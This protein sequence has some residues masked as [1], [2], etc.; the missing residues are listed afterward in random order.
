MK[1]ATN[2]LNNHIN[3]LESWDENEIS[4][5]K[6]LDTSSIAVEEWNKNEILKIKS[7]T[8]KG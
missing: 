2:I 4:Y 5:I 6:D 8:K 3:H 1:Y 7:N